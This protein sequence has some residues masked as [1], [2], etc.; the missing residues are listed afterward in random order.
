MG[1]GDQKRFASPCH[2]HDLA[3]VHHHDIVRNVVE[4]WKFVVMK[5]ID[6]MKPFSIKSRSIF[7]TIFCEVTSSAEEGSSAIKSLVKE[8]LKSRSLFSV[9]YRQTVQP[10]S[11][12]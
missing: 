9:S 3:G 7:M 12:Q 8:L 1:E 2:I 6:L 4:K 11:F 10:V 5:I